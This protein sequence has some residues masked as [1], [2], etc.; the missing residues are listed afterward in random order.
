MVAHVLRAVAVA[1]FFAQAP[2][3]WAQSFPN[4]PIRLVVPNPAGGTADLLARAIARGIHEKTGSPV[5]VDNRPGAAG[6]TATQVVSRSDPDGYTLL[7]TNEAP[8]TMIPVLRKETPYDPTAMAAI[9]IVASMPFYMVV[10]AKLGVSSVHDFIKLARQRTLHYGSTGIGGAS[11][12]L[13]ELFADRS[14]LKLAHIPYQGGPQAMT[15]LM[16]GEV[17]LFF[18]IPTTALGQLS[19]K[20]ARFLAVTSPSRTIEAPNVPTMAE[21]G[22]DD[23]VVGSWFGLLGPPMM[24]DQLQNQLAQLV[25]SSFEDQQAKDVVLKQGAQLILNAPADFR[26]HVAADIDK[27]KSIASKLN[28]TMD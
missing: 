2:T 19:A 28:L 24:P 5:L 1:F 4:K 12:L 22:I 11:H 15:N 16:S 25:R 8:I 14:D 26:K 13:T 18:S 7:F 27:W 10:N 17:D 9:S 21:Q 23:F 20:E 3:T 6:L